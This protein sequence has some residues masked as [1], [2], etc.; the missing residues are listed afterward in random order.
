MLRGGPIAVNGLDG[1]PQHLV[2]MLKPA[3]AKFWD[4]DRL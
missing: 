4:A 3:L 2:V 1:R